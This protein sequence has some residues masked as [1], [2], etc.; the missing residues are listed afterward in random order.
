VNPVTRAFELYAQ[1]SADGADEAMSILHQV[2]NDNPD[3]IDALCLAGRIQYDAGHFAFTETLLQRALKNK[4]D[5]SSAW[6]EMGRARRMMQDDEGA[7]RCFINGL[8]VSGDKFVGYQNLLVM[9]NALGC[10]EKTLELAPMARFLCDSEDDAMDLNGNVAIA[11]LM[12]RK[13]AQGWANYDGLLKPKMLRGRIDYFKNGEQLPVWNGSPGGEVIVYGEQGIGDEIMFTSM[14]PDM[15]SAGT[16]P[17]IHCDRRLEAMFKRSFDCPVYG[18]RGKGGPNEWLEK[19]DPKATIAIGSLGQY[20][21]RR[22]EDFPR[23]GYLK[24]DPEKRAMV[25]AL[26]D[27]WPGRKIGIAWTAGTRK[28]RTNERSLSLKELKPLLDMPDITWV[29]L[30]YKGGKPDDDRIKHL[31]F[32]T[33]SQDYDDTAALVAELD[34]VVCP[35]TSVAHLA[36]A[37]GQGCHV[38]VNKTP[39]WHWCKIGDSPWHDIK[40]YRRVA[41]DWS[42]VVWQVKRDLEAV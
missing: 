30:E 3:D 16:V 5:N 14:I 38:M 28:T 26:L 2:L 34:S 1:H 12:L 33:Q 11:S 24:A 27:Q 17:V 15:I 22:E 37:L 29:S 25:R 20:Y 10:P 6:I 36:G 41:N 31:P 13:W 32:L 19:H 40:K 21:R 4:V 8:R 42:A 39:T 18:G 9:N 35:T 7:A 23:V